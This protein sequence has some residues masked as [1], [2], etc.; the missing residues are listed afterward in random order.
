MLPKQHIVTFVG[1][2]GVKDVLH[3][4]DVSDMQV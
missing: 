4:A 1:K 3:L 2:I